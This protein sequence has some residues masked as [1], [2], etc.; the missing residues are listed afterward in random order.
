M[1]IT[2]SSPK[3][4]VNHTPKIDVTFQQFP[5]VDIKLST[6]SWQHF[7]VSNNGQLLHR[8]K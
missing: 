1:L 8:P 6:N 5:S 3:H 4:L 2:G 7:F